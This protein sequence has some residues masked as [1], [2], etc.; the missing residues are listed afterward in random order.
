MT[1][2]N[3]VH[4][5]AKNLKISQKILKNTKKSQK[6]PKIPENSK[7]RTHFEGVFTPGKIIFSQN[8]KMN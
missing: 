5:F 1:L 6:I 4:Y 7:S 2:K 3:S 8:A